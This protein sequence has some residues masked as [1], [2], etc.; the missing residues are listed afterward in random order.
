MCLSIEN[1]RTKNEAQQWFNNP[2]ITTKDVLVY[3]ILDRS[4]ISPY[5]CFKYEQNKTYKIK[6]F[7]SEIYP[8][9]IDEFVLEINQGLHSYKDKTSAEFLKNKF[10]NHDCNYDYRVVEMLVPKGTAY[11]EN[12]TQIV[13]LKL[14]YANE[15]LNSYEKFIRYLKRLHKEI[16]LYFKYINFK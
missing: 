15:N 1:F 6:E 3:K 2:K 14:L 11:F 7:S 4:N 9:G 10:N 12:E 8:D 5:Q 16:K 13:S